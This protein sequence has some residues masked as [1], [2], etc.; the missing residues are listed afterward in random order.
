MNL[1]IQYGK[2]T[3]SLLAQAALHML[4]Q[5]IGAP[6]SEQ[7]AEGKA[8]RTQIMAKFRFEDLGIGRY[9][10]AKR[11]SPLREKSVTKESP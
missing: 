3:M 10:A 7:S 2:M 1:N 11:I 6:V 9:Q 4:R 5:R 8:E